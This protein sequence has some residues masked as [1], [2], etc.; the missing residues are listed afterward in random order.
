MNELESCPFCGGKA[1]VGYAHPWFMLKRLHNR[2]IGVGC[3][4]CG[5]STMLFE[6]KKSGSPLMNKYYEEKA[7]QKAIDAWNKRAT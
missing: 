6:V 4:K 5:A 7:K 1:K 2:Y 3:T